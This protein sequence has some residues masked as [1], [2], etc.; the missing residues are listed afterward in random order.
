MDISGIIENIDNVKTKAQLA[1]YKEKVTGQFEKSIEELSIQAAQLGGL[2]NPAT[3]IASMIS[4]L[5]P[6]VKTIEKQLE[7]M[8]TGLQKLN[9]AFKNKE[10]ELA[11]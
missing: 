11:V 4:M 10:A 6:L 2:T 3:F 1:E 9:L 7:G 8:T 5:A